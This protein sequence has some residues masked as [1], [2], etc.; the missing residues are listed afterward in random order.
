MLCVC[1]CGVCVCT[2]VCVHLG[3]FHILAIVNNAVMNIA[4]EGNYLFKILI[5]ITLGNYPE[6]GLL[7]HMVVLLLIF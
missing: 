1:V 4:G 5:S 7:D 3:Y 2:H 6:V